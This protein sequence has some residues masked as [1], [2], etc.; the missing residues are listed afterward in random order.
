MVPELIYIGML[1][2]GIPI[3][4]LTSHN[5]FDIQFDQLGRRF[6]SGPKFENAEY[7]KS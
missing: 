2:K 7:A 3:L 5:Y 4:D 1:A 6:V